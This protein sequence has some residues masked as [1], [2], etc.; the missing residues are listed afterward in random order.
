VL[1]LQDINPSHTIPL[2]EG[3]SFDDAKTVLKSIA[4]VHSLY[5]HTKEERESLC[6]RDGSL[7]WLYPDRSIETFFLEL[8]TNLSMEALPKLRQ[9]MLSEM[10][11]EECDRIV[12][13]CRDLIPFI[14]SIQRLSRC[15][16]HASALCHGDFWSNNILFVPEQGPYNDSCTDQRTAVLVDWQFPCAD[17]PLSDVY[18]LLASSM[19][20]DIR[21]RHEKELLRF[22]Y[23]LIQERLG[24]KLS[25]YSLEMCFADYRLAEG[26]ALIQ[27]LSSIDAFLAPNVERNEPSLVHRLARFFG[28]VDYG[29]VAA[30][31][32]SLPSEL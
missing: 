3:L 16:A 31:V 5:W 2:R 11:I 19:D 13:Q 4:E 26:A 1:L 8:I 22:Y 27:V 7:S 29:R 10:P 14:P 6:E 9:A 25:S 12:M 15:K 17:N 28:D 24:S 18:F 32:A 30:N 20:P 23:E 21:K